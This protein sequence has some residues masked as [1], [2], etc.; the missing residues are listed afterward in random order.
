MKII[1]YVIFVP[2]A[3]ILL[4]AF[5]FAGFKALFSK[6]KANIKSWWERKKSGEAA[7]DAEITDP[8]GMVESITITTGTCDC[9]G[10]TFVGTTE[11]KDKP[12]QRVKFMGITKNI[13]SDCLKKLFEN[14]N[15]SSKKG[16][17]YYSENAQKL[18]DMLDN[19]NFNKES[20][21][22]VNPENKANSQP[23]K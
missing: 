4:C 16:T 10:R 18:K 21:N 14:F 19:L 22:S 2:L 6:M 17:T 3:I 1:I 9:C 5:I 7:N 11:D 15:K 8:E 23:S 13:C 12:L 20:Q